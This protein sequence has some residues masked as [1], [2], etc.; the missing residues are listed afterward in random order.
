MRTNNTNER[1]SL[2]FILMQGGA[3]CQM[4]VIR[5]LRPGSAVDDLRTP[6]GIMELETPKRTTRRSYASSALL[7]F[8]AISE[9]GLKNYQY[10]SVHR[11]GLERVVPE[12]IH[13]VLFNCDVRAPGRSPA[14]V[15]ERAVPAPER[16]GGS[17]RSTR[18]RGSSTTR[19]P[20]RRR[21]R[22]RT[23]PL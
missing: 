4:P 19:A 3:V 11:A 14:R 17:L 2:S 5:N 8:S 1:C 7:K 18:R 16:T 13:A 9:Y 6:A 15:G 22:R 12:A 20:G 21:S 10:D 23:G